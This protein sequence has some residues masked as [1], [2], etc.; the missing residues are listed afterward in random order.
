MRSSSELGR[1]LVDEGLITSTQLT[2]AL[3]HQALIGGRVGTNL[4]EQGAITEDVLLGALGRFRQTGV[5]SRSELGAIPADVLRLV[6][7]KLAHRYRIVP[8]KR[9]GRTLLIASMDPGDVLVEDEISMLTSCLARTQI[10]L[11]VRMHEA[12]ARYYR[13]R[14]PR[15]VVTLIKR[16][17]LAK[18]AARAVPKPR[19]DTPV[20]PLDAVLPDV[21][22]LLEGPSSEPAP[23]SPRTDTPPA[24]QEPDP[25]LDP[26]PAD[27]TPLNTPTVAPAPTVEA[28]PPS[29]NLTGSH[30]V[31]EHDEE[32]AGA[33]EAV[34]ESGAT[35]APDRLD[36]LEAWFQ[37][38]RAEAT[39][40]GAPP[41]GVPPSGAP[42]SGVPPSGAPPTPPP[43]APPSEASSIDE[44]AAQERPTARPRG[45]DIKEIELDAEDLA[46]LYGGPPAAEPAA[47]DPAGR[48]HQAADALQSADIRDEIA[49]AVL[50]FCA[51]YFH[52]RLLLIVRQDEIVGWRGEGDGVE[53]ATVRTIR[54]E[55]SVPSAFFGLLQGAELWRGPLPT[56][57]A[58]QTLVAGLGGERPKD[59]LI[60]PIG[61]RGRVVSFLYVDNRGE[62]IATTPVDELRRLAIKAGVAF[63]VHILRNKI[64]TL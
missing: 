19:V 40:S 1:F 64:R 54:L 4:L 39:S 25:R 14:P 43:V 32:E 57:P 33:T 7:L 9:R 42:P 29:E 46:L 36:D 24:S 63:E 8:Y 52:R 28:S 31:V 17:G 27:P 44:P 37:R 10:A 49:D 35:A 20:K 6:P 51:P 56:L 47:E 30:P 12:L 2:K 26:A 50:A 23:P 55:K 16:L 58:N 18:T 34:L 45:D 5:V 3:E 53:T 22:A 62:G 59:C 11:E 41:S 15:R 48:L 61:L 21:E 13:L 38:R 60:L